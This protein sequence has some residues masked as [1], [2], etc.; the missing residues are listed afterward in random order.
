MSI[1]AQQAW[2]LDVLGEPVALPGT[3]GD[4]HPGHRRGR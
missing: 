1:Q 4:I 2:I 3:P